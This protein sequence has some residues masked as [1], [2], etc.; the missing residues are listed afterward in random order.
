MAAAFTVEFMIR[1]I[2][3]PGKGNQDRGPRPGGKH[4]IP[5]QALQAK[6]Q[7]KQDEWIE[8]ARFSGQIKKEH[9]NRMSGPATCVNGYSLYV[10]RLGIEAGAGPIFAR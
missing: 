10:L 5:H 4:K 7:E 6:R 8:A 2:H 9:G 3:Q 1:A